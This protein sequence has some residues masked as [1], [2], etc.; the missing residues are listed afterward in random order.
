MALGVGILGDPGDL[1][2]L[3]YVGVLAVGAIGAVV[4]R[5]RP[6]GMAR[7]LFAT[8]VGQALVAVIVLSTEMQQGP[9]AGTMLIL[10]GLFVALFAGSAWLF[11]HAARAQSK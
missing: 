11:R 9:S 10:N 6:D 5:F 8:A 7:A 2:D 4:A 3:M 1:A